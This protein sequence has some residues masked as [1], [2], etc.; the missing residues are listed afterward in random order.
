MYPVINAP[1]NVPLGHSPMSFSSCFSPNFCHP[2]EKWGNFEIS[3]LSTSGND[4]LESPPYNLKIF[5]GFKENILSRHTSSFF[6][7]SKM[8]QKFLSWLYD[9][10]CPEEF[11]FATLSRISQDDYFYKGQ[12][13]Q[14]I[15]RIKK[16]YLIKNLTQTSD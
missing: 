3:R 9:T 8:A 16:S 5:K 15:S 13:T 10:A 14:G 6:I 1:I 12:I 2:S 4:L 11:F 7:R